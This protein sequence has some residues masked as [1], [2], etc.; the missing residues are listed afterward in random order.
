MKRR[1]FPLLIPC[2]TVALWGSN[3]TAL[4]SFGAEAGLVQSVSE[5]SS[6]GT[7]QGM[8]QMTARDLLNSQMD[9]GADA[10]ADAMTQ[11]AGD[12]T[13]DA[14]AQAA[15]S[16]S[17]TVEIEE[18]GTPLSAGP[19]DDEYSNLAIADVDNY[20]N[21]R[22][23]P[24][25]NGE[26]MGKMYD[27]SVAQVLSTTGSGEDAWFQ[28]VSGDVQGYIKAEFFLYG[29]EAAAVIDDYV[30]KYAKVK[31]D[32]LNVRQSPDIEASRIGYLDNGEK[33][34]LLEND[35]EWMKVEYADGQAG[36]VAGE[37]VTIEEEFLHAKSIAEE[38]AELEAQR[39]AAARAAQSEAAAPEDTTITVSAPASYST[40]EELRSSIVE[41]AKQ[42]LGNSYRSGGR[43][44]ESGTDC[45]GFTCYLFAEFGYSLSRTPQGQWTSNGRSISA[46][47]AQPGDIV[48]YSS[49]GSKCTHVAL[50]LGDGQII[51][52]ANS[53]RGV[54]IDSIYYDDTYI[55][56]KNVID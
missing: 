13:G 49:N 17:S 33:A 15:D 9:A 7:K 28:V 16:S 6:A 42:F 23:T 41:Y 25:T 35:G 48:C 46:E 56:V 52:S 27:G 37:Y 47:E 1:L 10:I 4:E 38:Q 32:R 34:K 24:D 54:V 12:A 8:G 55:G 44:L 29:E 5:E 11:A 43:S 3:L 18:G 30:T 20:V 50:Y 22:S 21:V 2:L 45:S 19:V 40:N 53:R 31:A 51:H 36:W 14:S 39:K 26:V